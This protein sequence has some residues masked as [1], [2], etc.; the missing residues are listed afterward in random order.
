M[1]MRAQASPTEH[2]V[3]YLESLT[4]PLTWGTFR[5]VILL[6]MASKNWPE[7]RQ[8]AARLHEQAHIQRCDWLIYVLTR[9][10]VSLLW[11]HPLAWWMHRQ[12]I[13]EAEHAADDQVLAAGVI[14][15]DYASLLLSI[16]APQRSLALAAAQHDIKHRIFAILGRRNRTQ[17]RAHIGIAACCVVMMGLP[18]L[19]ATP[20]WHP[21]P[22]ASQSCQPGQTGGTAYVDDLAPPPL[23]A[24]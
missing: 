13:R 14:P 8:V 12:L 19:A 21:T 20:L 22:E 11:F 23:L 15:S 16:A 5:P 9:T 17:H 10:I 7:A 24:R 4:T 18:T 2:T 6:P 1:T 3:R